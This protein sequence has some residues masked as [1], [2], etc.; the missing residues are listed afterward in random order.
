VLYRV[1]VNP[2]LFDPN[3]DPN[4]WNSVAHVL[5][6]IIENGKLVSLGGSELIDEIADRVREVDSE[7]S[8]G[9]RPLLSTLRDLN[10]IETF[11]LVG[12]SKPKSNQEWLAEALAASN[13]SDLPELF[14]IVAKQR[15][16]EKCAAARGR[17]VLVAVERAGTNERWNSRSS[18]RVVG[19]HRAGVIGCVGDEIACAKR[20]QII[21]YIL[22]R[23]IVYGQESA[24][25]FTGALGDLL[26]IWG[27][28]D[29][30]RVEFLI[31]TWAFVP[32]NRR[33]EIGECREH[34]SEL[35]HD[36]RAFLP[37]DESKVAV[38]F[39]SGTR[40][41]PFIKS[42]FLITEAACIQVAK[43]FDLVDTESTNHP[44]PIT[45]FDDASSRKIEAPF[46]QQRLRQIGILDLRQS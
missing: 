37:S 25:R 24:V 21:D 1:T 15:E 39:W 46:T 6:G 18:A 5:R 4:H 43:G 7:F 19:R 2:G 40:N 44:E 35:R 32:P 14:A 13:D 34:F 30:E 8:A 27:R 11:P 20:V 3:R 22:F 16:I 45:L 31:D 36:L 10:R 29:R 33:F 23:A 9:I 42:R 28:G 38:R 17:G 26:Q 41:T 12:P